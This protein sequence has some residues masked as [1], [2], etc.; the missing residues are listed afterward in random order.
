MLNWERGQKI[1]DDIVE[2]FEACVGIRFPATYKKIVS[3]YNGGR[4]DTYHIEFLMPDGSLNVTSFGALMKFSKDFG[5]MFDFNSKNQA[6]EPGFIVFADDP[7]GWFF[8]F[9][10]RE[11]KE[12]P[13]VY[14]IRSDLSFPK[15]LIFIADN[16]EE[17]LEKLTGD[18]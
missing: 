13:S 6:Y 17:F 16:F 1:D 5:D 11:V 2:E 7:R 10:Y 15:N 8:A 4:P 3:L 9:D 18:V 14:L 12:N